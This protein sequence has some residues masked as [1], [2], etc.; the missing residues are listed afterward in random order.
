M[1][2]D[3]TLHFAHLPRRS[4]PVPQIGGLSANKAISDGMTPPLPGKQAPVI[5]DVNINGTER[6]IDDAGIEDDSDDERANRSEDEDASHL[7]QNEP[8]KPRKISQKKK[9]EQASFGLWLEANRDKLSKKPENR[10]TDNDQSVG[11]LVKSWEGQKIIN[12]PRDYQMELFQRAKEK[13]TIAVL[14][15]GKSKTIQLIQSFGHSQ[16]LT[17]AELPWQ[18]IWKDS[19]S[20]TPSPARHRKRA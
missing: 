17:M 2:L 4:V 6:T 20:G 10:I 16:W 12:N 3:R 11:Y 15:T 1:T 7:V 9:I 18:R 19:D 13:N 5:L 14:D 8:R